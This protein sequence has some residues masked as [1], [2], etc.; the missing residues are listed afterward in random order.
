MRYDHMNTIPEL[1]FI[2][3][4]HRLFQTGSGAYG[5][6][7]EERTCA[8][9]VFSQQQA[10]PDFQRLYWR[11]RQSGPDLRPMPPNRRRQPPQDHKRI[12][13][14]QPAERQRWWSTP[15]DGSFAVSTTRAMFALLLRQRVA[16]VWSSDE[17]KD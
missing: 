3:P 7:I 5:Q 6:G 2:V 16:S 1:S 11:F 14:L 10:Q 8:G 17:K 12:Q 13:S 15:D 4:L 9:G